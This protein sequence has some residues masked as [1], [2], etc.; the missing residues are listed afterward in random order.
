MISQTTMQTLSG[1]F[2]IFKSREPAEVLEVKDHPE[3]KYAAVGPTTVRESTEQSESTADLADSER[4]LLW[5][6]TGCTGALRM[7]GYQ[8]DLPRKWC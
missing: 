5:P 8:A 1:R 4:E 7:T 6:A 3:R 2:H